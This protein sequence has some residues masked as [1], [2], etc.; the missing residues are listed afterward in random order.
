[1]LRL[2]AH[3]P[4]T[5]AV[6]ILRLSLWH[7]AGVALLAARL[8]LASVWWRFGMGKFQTGWLRGWL[9]GDP[10]GIPNPLTP[11]LRAIAEGHMPV[12]FGLYRPVA[13]ALLALRLDAVLAAIV[14]ITEVALAAAFLLGLAP[15][16]W[17]AIG[18]LVNVNLLLSAIGSPRIDGPVMVL[19]LLLLAAGPLGAR[20]S[21]VSL[22]RTLRAHAH[23]AAT[24]LPRHT[25]SEWPAC[26]R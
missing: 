23:L 26:G 19:E 16:R 14:P 4:R 12:P 22:W 17:A 6:A 10:L 21:P 18:L 7:V 3:A 13:Q 24:G 8:Q 1:M 20:W 11:I 25:T 2:D 9:A 5:R 15:R